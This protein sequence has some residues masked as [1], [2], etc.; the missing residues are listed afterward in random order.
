MKMA[1][2][3]CNGQSTRLCPSRFPLDC[4]HAITRPC[5]SRDLPVM[6]GQR[7]EWAPVRSTTLHVIR[8]RG[9]EISERFATPEH[10]V[11]SR[12]A[13]LAATGAAVL[14]LSP[15]IAL[16][17]RISD[18]PDPTKDLYPV[19]RYEKYTLD[20]PVTDEKFN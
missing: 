5:H 7:I 15:K 6:G 20:R 10:L 16:A 13:L 9:W 1:A 4:G 12:R 8:R 3:D 11:L 2:L 14:S 17:Q 19:K 18:L